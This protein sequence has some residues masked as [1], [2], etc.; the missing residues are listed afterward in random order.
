MKRTI[1]RQAQFAGA[2][3]HAGLDMAAFSLDLGKFRAEY[4]AFSDTNTFTDD[5]LLSCYETAGFYVANE[6]YGRLRDRA[7]EKA[8]DL[9][10][11]HLAALSVIVSEGGSPS[12]AQAASVDKVSVTMTPPPVK[13]QYAW[14]LSTTPYGMQLLA[15]LNVKSAG[16]FF[17]GGSDTRGG[18]RSN[19][20][21][22]R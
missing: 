9:M 13:S 17:V 15:L 10:T 1:R 19:A 6:N 11:A 8:L 7:R 2:E 5:V 12:V 14:W 21:F 3:N 16:G 4:P 22:I 20:G 18:F